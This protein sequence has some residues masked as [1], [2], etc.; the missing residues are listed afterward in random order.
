MTT[1]KDRKFATTAERWWRELTSE[2]SGQKKTRGPR[3]A[4]LARLRRAKTPLE[5]LQEP[6]ALRLIER[7]AGAPPDRVAILAGVLAY[8]REHDAQLV[9]SAIGRDKLDDETALMSENRFRRLLQV[10]SNELLDPMRR[11][12]HLTKGKANVFDLSFAILCW[13]ERV[14]KHWIFRYYGVSGN[15]GST[16]SSTFFSTST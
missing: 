9:G 7:L 4:A 6:E 2:D 1:S 14:K 3:R 11:L 12:V 5:I 16:D 8:V 15:V 13:G 10:S